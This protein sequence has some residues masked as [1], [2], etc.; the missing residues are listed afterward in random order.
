MVSGSATTIKGQVLLS[1]SASPTSGGLGSF[2]SGLA[3][4]AN[5]MLLTTLPYS[6][7][8]VLNVNYYVFVSDNL[9]TNLPPKVFTYLEASSQGITVDSQGDFLAAVYLNQSNGPVYGLDVINST[10]STYGSI[11]LANPNPLTLGLRET[12]RSPQVRT[13]RTSRF[14]GSTKFSRQRTPA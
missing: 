1:S 4:N 8:G 11:A 6:P 10:V 7:T 12:S 13:W 3:I 9:N 2:P 14:R 5:G